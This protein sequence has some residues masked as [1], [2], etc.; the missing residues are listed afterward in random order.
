MMTKRFAVM[1]LAG[2]AAA[3][4]CHA[5]VGELAGSK[6]NIVLVMTDDQGDGQLG[7]QGHPWLETPNIDKLCKQSTV[8]IDFHVSPTCS[9]TRAALLTGNVPFKNGVTHTVKA[10]HRLA[11][12]AVTL[13]QYLKQAGYTSGIFGKWHLGLEEPYQPGARGFDEVF[14]HG[15]GAIGQG[16]DVPKN[17]Y[18]DPV[19]RHNGTFVK[20]KGF[21]TD[22]FFSQALGWIQQNKDKPFFAY[23]P[24]N[25]PHSP[26]VAPDHKM[27]KF[28]QYGFKEGM[29]GFYGMIENIDENVGR[30][31]ARLKE[32]GL[33]ENTLVIFMSDNGFVLSGV[34]NGELG[35]REGKS[36]SAFTAGLKGA[37]GTVHEGGTRVPAFFHWK[38]VLTEGAEVNALSAHIDILPTLVDLAGGELSQSIDGKSLVPLLKDPSAQRGDRKLFFH[39]GRWKDNVG[40]DKSKYAKSKS[41]GFAVRSSRYRLVN[42]EELYDILSDPGETKN[43]YSQKPE[44]VQEM[45]AAYDQWWDEVRPYMVNEGKE[46]GPNPYHEKYK[47]QLSEE[48]IP[49][50]EK[51]EL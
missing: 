32:W 51:P 1:A 22:V 3:H 6:P 34:G 23:I 9:P 25:A 24:T 5:S 38:G 18:Y 11:R 28:S 43:I 47:E 40:P 12:S 27:E 30:L 44:V 31:M 15:Y 21:C 36:L 41:M 13:P 10:R 16:L 7:C 33:E 50:W 19:I 4:F 49:A 48:G 46:T 35:V 42:N 26:F 37:K 17:N 39:N 8:F 29:Q 2:M 45:R 20:T 14:V